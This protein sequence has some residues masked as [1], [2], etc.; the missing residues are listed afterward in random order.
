MS[1]DANGQE[2]TCPGDVQSSNSLWDG[3][4]QCV[5]AL[6]TAKF[7]L[8]NKKLQVKLFGT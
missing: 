6:A 3:G 2:C 5:T 7:S 1:L 4:Q 8:M